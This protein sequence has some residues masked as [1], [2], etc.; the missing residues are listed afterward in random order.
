M[1]ATVAW[2]LKC[3][4]DVG[5]IVPLVAPVF[6]RLQTVASDFVRDAKLAG[7][8]GLVLYPGEQLVGRPDVWAEIAKV[9]A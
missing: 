1:G 7:C 2:G 6:N 9:G 8:P 3:G 4:W 5:Q